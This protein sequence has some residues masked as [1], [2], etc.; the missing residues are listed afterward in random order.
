MIIAPKRWRQFVIPLENGIIISRIGSIS[1]DGNDDDDDDN[2][3]C[4][5][6]LKQFFTHSHLQCNPQKLSRPI[7]ACIDLPAD[8]ERQR[9]P[10][11]PP[12]QNKLEYLKT[13]DVGSVLNRHSRRRRC[14]CP[15]TLTPCLLPMLVFK[16][17]M[18][19][20]R[21]I[22][23]VLF[24]PSIVGTRGF[25]SNGRSSKGR[26]SCGGPL[27]ILEMGRPQFTQ[28]IA[29]SNVLEPSSGLFW[30]K[31]CALKQIS[32]E[33]ILKLPR[34]GLFCS[35]LGKRRRLTASNS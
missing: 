11:P 29:V 1:L 16:W 8:R 35:S 2:G 18:L 9:P 28:S 7:R 17:N 14:L 13:G 33:L 3:C 6:P 5:G 12:W 24:P 4:I 26:R 10:P 15:V 19:L 21:F 23:G 20:H 34:W 27:G 31:L 30:R 32:F 22:S 25:G